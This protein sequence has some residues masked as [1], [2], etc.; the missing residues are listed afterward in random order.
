MTV[1]EWVLLVWMVLMV[2]ALILFGLLAQDTIKAYRR[3]LEKK[4]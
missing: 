3:Y 1:L 2:L 4:H